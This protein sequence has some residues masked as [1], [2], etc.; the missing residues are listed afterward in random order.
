MIRQHGLRIFHPLR[1]RTISWRIRMSAMNA[2]RRSPAGRRRVFAGFSPR[3]LPHWRRGKP[4]LQFSSAF[5][6]QDLRGLPQ[7]RHRH[8][9]G[10]EFEPFWG[11]TLFKRG[12]EL[13]ALQRGN[14]EMCNLAPADIK[15]RS[16]RGRS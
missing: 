10:Y 14:L 8:Q 11:N 6:E 1:Q 2:R 9:D 4:K 12:T 16:R 5:T 3:C 7:L 15:S 13:V